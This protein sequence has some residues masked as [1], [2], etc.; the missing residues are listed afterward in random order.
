MQSPP[1]AVLLIG[2]WAKQPGD[3]HGV[4]L[5]HFSRPL[6]PYLPD[7]AWWRIGIVVRICGLGSPRWREAIRPRGRA[8]GKERG[9]DNEYNDCFGGHM[10]WVISMLSGHEDTL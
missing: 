5:F 6:A 3:P 9:A 8:R 4:S 10:N 2:D 7:A 1:S